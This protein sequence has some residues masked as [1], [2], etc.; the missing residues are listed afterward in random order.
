MISSL[1]QLIHINL[2][3]GLFSFKN[4]LSVK[5][6]VILSMGAVSL[7]SLT[8]LTRNP[9]IRRNDPGSLF[10]IFVER[11]RAE[12]FCAFVINVFSS[13]RSKRRSD[14]RYCFIFSRIST[15]SFREPLIPIIQSSAYLTYTNFL[16][17]VSIAALEGILSISLCRITFSRSELVIAFLVDSL[18]HSGF[19]EALLPLSNSAFSFITNSS[20]LC[21]Y[22]LARI[23]LIMDPGGVP[24]SECE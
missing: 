15:H 9:F 16:N 24:I 11:N 1:L 2:G 14:L 18:F 23:G 10:L 12:S 17:L 13:D 4:P 20:S 6:F 7:I 8:F 5:I 19:V 22:K 3:V 21:K